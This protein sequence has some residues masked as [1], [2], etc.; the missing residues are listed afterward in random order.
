MPV[1]RILTRQI[2]NPCRIESAIKHKRII[3]F[4]NARA[5]DSSELRTSRTTVLRSKR[6]IQ[7]RVL[8]CQ[9]GKDYD[10]KTT[11]QPA[12]S[13]SFWCFP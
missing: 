3:L 12:L 1:R 8:P 6:V 5:I 10:L 2:I 13:Y 4:I 9:G 7:S 11:Y